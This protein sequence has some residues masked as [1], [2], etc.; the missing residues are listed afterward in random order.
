MKSDDVDG[1]DE[2]HTFQLLCE[3]N[4]RYQNQHLNV[5]NVFPAETG[6]W[7]AAYIKVA[8]DDSF[9]FLHCFILSINTIKILTTCNF[10]LTRVELAT[11]R[12]LGKGN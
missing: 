4:F 5:V 2:V 9:F 11:E 8:R 10:V 7:G 12:P 6:C 1:G 3:K